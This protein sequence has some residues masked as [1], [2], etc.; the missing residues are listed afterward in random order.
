MDITDKT[1][2]LVS[3]KSVRDDEDLMIIN[4]SG[5]TI[6]MAVDSIR[7]A[8]RATQ[9]VKL[10]SIREKDSIAAVSV[11]PKQ[12]DETPVAAENQAVENETDAAAVNDQNTGT[13]KE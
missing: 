11:V 7:V 2:K 12:E 3:I 1:G 6:R 8:G 5:L 4:K 10:I 13:E 9:G